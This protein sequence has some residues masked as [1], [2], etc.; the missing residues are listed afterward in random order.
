M[1]CQKE[2]FDGCCCECEYRKEIHKHPWNKGKAKGSILELFG[3]VCTAHSGN[4]IFSDRK[5][6]MCEEYIKRNEE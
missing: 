6:G 2:I 3:Y 1:E 4:W 5:C